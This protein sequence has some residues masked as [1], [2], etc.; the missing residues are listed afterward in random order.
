MLAALTVPAAACLWFDTNNS[1]LFS[2]YEPLEFRISVEQ[3]CNDNWKAYLGS[4]EEYFSFDAD[5]AIKVARKKNDALMVSYIQNLAKY[6][7]CAEEKRQE[8]WDY[9]TKE[10][11][12]KRRQTLTAVRNYAQT[13]LKSRL[14]SQHALLLMRC[15]MM[16]G[17][18][19]QNVTFW[20]TTGS[21]F[22]NSVYR[23]MMLN[24]YAGA[25]YKTGNDQEAA[26]TFAAQGDWESL[27][28]MY[29]KKRS[30]AAIRQ[31]YLRQ[32]DSAVLPF[33]LKDFVNNAQEA[34]DAANDEFAIGGK[35]FIRNITKQEAM[36]MCQL[37]EQVVREGKTDAPA[38]WQSAKAWLEYLFGNVKQGSADIAKAETLNGTERMKDNVRVLKFYI[39]GSQMKGGET[40]DNYVAQE[41]AWL[42]GKTEKID[43]FTAAQSRIVHQVLM[44]RYE[45]QPLRLLAIERLTGCAEYEACIDT[46]RVESLLEY[47]AYKKSPASNALDKYLKDGLKKYPEDS[48]Y[49]MEFNDLVATKYLRL[50]Q[51]DKAVEWLQK[52]PLSFYQQKGYAYYA[53]FR[54][55]DVEPW[56]RRQW[57]DEN[58]ERQPR[59]VKTNPKLAF[60]QEMRTM[61][62]KLNVLEGKALEQC[63]YEL[64]VRYAQAHFTGDCWYLMRDGKS[65]LDTLRSNEADLAARA[66]SLLQTASRSTDFL[67]REKALFALSYSGLY[68]APW[69]ESV[70]SDQANDFVRKPDSRSAQ[71]KAFASLQTFEQQNATRTSSYVSRCDEYRQFCKYRR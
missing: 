6:L 7:K 24:I 21:K 67:L 52:V 44:K 30:Y 2:P 27:M 11:L 48:D 1:Y 4:T 3:T 34:I 15:N 57:G 68:A 58:D 22:I 5:E 36:Q 14:R 49:L 8:Q 69:Y 28:T 62:A 40:F 56:I 71:Y 65:C 45:S 13:K 29:Y 61:E 47:M 32:P 38:M 25:L 26:Q 50:R 53:A 41:M 9:P 66:I 55:T 63:S 43:F 42:Q 17:Q 60:A 31:E 19:A 12:A 33:L 70:W 39:N 35:L 10:Q 51:W 18:H 23:D 37:C 46:I 54:K 20:N 64:A 16:L 59:K